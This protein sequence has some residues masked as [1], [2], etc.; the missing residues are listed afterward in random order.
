MQVERCDEPPVAVNLALGAANCLND[1][2]LYRAIAAKFL[3]EHLQDAHRIN[4]GLLVGHWAECRR[5]AHTLVSSAATVG[6]APLSQLARSLYQA[7]EAQDAGAVEALNIRLGFE[8]QR[9]Q[10]SLTA[11]LEREPG[12]HR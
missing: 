1:A 10:G 5:M 9:V 6:A 7:L 11:L 2:S 12:P 8:L 3:T 4:Q